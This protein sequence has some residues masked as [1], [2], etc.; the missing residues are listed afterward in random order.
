MI[1]FADTYENLV[2]LLMSETS[3]YDVNQRT[4]STISFLQD[5][6]SFAI[7]LGDNVLPTCGLRR[8]RPHLAAAEVAW[9]LLGSP[10]LKWLQKH[11]KIW[12]AFADAD[13]NVMEAY[14]HRWR[15][16]FG[17]D[18][19]QTALDRLTRDPSDRRVWISS[20]DPMFDLKDTGQKTVPCPVGFT[21]SAHENRINSSLMIRSSDVFI[22]LPI[23]VMRHA[24]LMRAIANS[25]NMKPGYMRVTLAHPHIYESHW[26]AARQMLNEDIRIP[27]IRMPQQ[28]WTV[29]HIFNCPDAYVDLIRRAVFETTDWPAY[30][31]QAKV[32][33]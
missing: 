30:D 16:A 27:D 21:L 1:R 22:G 8:T 32:V 24:L 28:P 5:G 6:Y 4:R 7:D 26:D 19:I 9:C 17:Y 2:S 18:Q 15:N 29:E 13:G 12:D 3:D 20:W 14:G 23:D 25:L 11:T 10:S 33:K 31:P